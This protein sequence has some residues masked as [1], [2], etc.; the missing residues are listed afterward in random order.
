MMVYAQETRGL[1]R[2]CA[3]WQVISAHP[4]GLTEAAANGSLVTS[5]QPPKER[6]SMQ[7]QMFS[8]Q[9]IYLPPASMMMEH[10]G[11]DVRKEQCHGSLPCWMHN[12]LNQKAAPLQ[13]TTV[14][15][16][17]LYRYTCIRIYICIHI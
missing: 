15:Y 12:T 5:T 10:T 14:I 9:H 16:I 17:Q 3:L 8:I 1:R 6:D 13:N 11:H 2:M 7:E 4:H